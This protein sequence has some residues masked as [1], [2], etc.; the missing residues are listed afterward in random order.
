MFCCYD[1][2][3]QPKDRKTL[4]ALPNIGLDA[5]LTGCSYSVNKFY[6]KS[7]KKNS[8][9]LVTNYVVKPASKEKLNYICIHFPFK[10]VKFTSVN[11]CLLILQI[12]FN[13]Y[14]LNIVYIPLFFFCLNSFN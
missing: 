13:N 8:F 7:I 3:N 1:G 2:K 5:L 14:C 9:F 6:V 10:A 12:R 4:S 11:H